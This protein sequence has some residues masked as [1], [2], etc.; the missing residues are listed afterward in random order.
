M[1]DSAPPLAP[2]TLPV[3]TPPPSRPIGSLWRRFLAFA[4]DT[5]LIAI[6]VVL[7]SIPFF[8]LLSELGA[9]GSLV[10][11]LLALPYFAILDSHIGNGQTLGK[12]WMHV[13][14]VDVQGNTISLE[15]A[16]LRYTVFAVPYFL[17]ELP[18]PVSRT[19]QIVSILLFLVVFCAGGATFYLIC[20]NRVTRQGLHD[21]AARA[22]V[23]DADMAGSVRAEPI[24]EVHW[25]ILSVVFVA[26][27]TATFA[28]SLGS[29]TRGPISEMWDDL[30][31]VEAMP[32]VQSAS[33]QLSTN[34]SKGPKERTL[35][36]NAHWAGKSED[37]EAFAD[38]I[39][40]AILAHDKDAEGYGSLSISLIRGYDLGIAHAQ[41]SRRFAHTIAQWNELLGKPSATG[42]DSTV[43]RE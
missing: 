33:M 15:R 37:A 12:R 39:A 27:T 7:F 4:I 25:A 40:A 42:K 14:V 9:W 32:G 17:N 34:W 6:P 24:W 43:I 22:Y 28:F 29:N 38:Q 31:I 23:A 21:L 5:I 16:L 13:R 30:R 35:V 11:F 3:A 36:V 26:I 18:L 41:V 19:P 8:D 20:F 2:D 10:G 1:N